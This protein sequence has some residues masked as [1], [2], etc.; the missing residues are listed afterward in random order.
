MNAQRFIRVIDEVSYWSAKTFAWLIVAA[1]L[2]I[3]VEV[4]SATS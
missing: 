2:V 4:S 3:S 1:T